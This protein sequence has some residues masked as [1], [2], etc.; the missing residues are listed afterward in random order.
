MS[1]ETTRCNKKL[2]H[3]RFIFEMVGGDFPG[4]AWD[5]IAADEK[6]AWKALCT[7]MPR[8]TQHVKRLE[9]VKISYAA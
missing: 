7:H 5:C 2:K 6:G 1:Y 4:G 9:K 3:F 8:A